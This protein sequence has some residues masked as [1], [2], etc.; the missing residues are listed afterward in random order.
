MKNIENT[1]SAKKFRELK[2]YSMN[3]TRK[4]VNIEYLKGY[5]DK[6]FFYHFDINLQSKPACHPLSRK[7]REIA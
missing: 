7:I 2:I 4:T 3:K 6:V 1:A 5:C